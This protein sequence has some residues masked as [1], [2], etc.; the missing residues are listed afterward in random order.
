MSV[1]ASVSLLE[2]RRTEADA[3]L[4]SLVDAY[5]KSQITSIRDKGQFSGD[6]GHLKEALIKEY[7]D[8][9][10]SAAG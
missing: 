8:L 5:A 4:L 9:L 3:E 10:E 2:S 1:Q 6:Y 7:L